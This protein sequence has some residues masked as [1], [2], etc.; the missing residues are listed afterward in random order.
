M[1]VCCSLLIMCWSCLYVA[2]PALCPA[3]VC[4]LFSHVC[5]LLTCCPYLYI[6]HCLICVLS[7]AH[8]LPMFDYALLMLVHA[9]CSS[10]VAHVCKLF[11][12]HHVW[13]ML[14]HCSG[15]I[16]CCSWLLN[17][18][19]CA[20]LLLMYVLV[21]YIAH[22]SLGVAYVYFMLLTAHYLS[23]IFSVSVTNPICDCLSEISPS[24]HLPVLREIPFLK[25][26]FKKPGLLWYWT[27]SLSIIILSCL[28]A[29]V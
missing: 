5:M 20:L 21:L 12:A 11:T 17:I 7:V 8:C 22:Y 15:L 6:A 4:Y 1:F 23:L 26:Q 28:L 24:L 10:C 18:V 25:I 13:C 27:C 29:F 19:H 14:V 16:R 3:C 9:H 2:H